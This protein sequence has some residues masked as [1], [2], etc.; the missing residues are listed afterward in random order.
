MTLGVRP[1]NSTRSPFHSRTNKRPNIA[2]IE[3]NGSI[4]FQSAPQRSDKRHK[5]G[6]GPPP[7][8][9]TCRICNVP[10]HWIQ[11]CPEKTERQK[12]AIPDSIANRDGK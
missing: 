6:H 4:F 7:E 9:Y 3:D 1:P 12:K 11:E 8:G 2:E 5:K 10:G